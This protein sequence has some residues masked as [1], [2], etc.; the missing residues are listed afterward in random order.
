MQNPQCLLCL[1]HTGHFMGAF[2]LGPGTL[3]RLTH[4]GPCHS[5]GDHFDDVDHDDEMTTMMI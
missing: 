5:G 3:R 2:Y 4:T 1:V